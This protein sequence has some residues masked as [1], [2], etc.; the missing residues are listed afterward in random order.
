MEESKKI[1]IGGK[2]KKRISNLIIQ[3]ILIIMAA[4]AI[5]PFLWMV[6][7]SLKGA[8]EAFAYPPSLIPEIFRWEN[9]KKALTDLPFDKAYFNSLKLAVINVTGQV[10]T[11]AMAGYALGKLKFRGSNVVFGGFITVMMVPYTVISIPL[12]LI[13]SELNLI[14]T[15]LAII[16]MTF[17]YMPMGVFLCRQFIMAL[18][19]ELIEA[20][21]IDGANYGSIFFRIIVPLIRPALAS[22]G[23]FSFM[24]N[25]NSFYTPLIFLN[26]QDKF[27]V[28]LLLNMFKGKYTVDWSLI[29]A[30]STISIIP[31]LIVY[32]FAQKHIIEGITI[33]GMKG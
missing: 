8:Q 25:W 28:P 20:A 6:S 16:L 24:W 9:Y 1:L 30:A 21:I 11:S 18:P 13:F 14:D 23:I 19:D 22:L 15:H 32:L 33:T 4:L 5:F 31:V 7:T 12:F 3:I 17:A 10:T 26:S 27:T 29:M 2:T